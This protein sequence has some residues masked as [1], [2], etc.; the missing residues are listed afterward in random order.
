[1]WTRSAIEDITGTSS[2]SMLMPPT[3][4][5]RARDESAMAASQEPPPPTRP[6][7]TRKCED[8]RTKAGSFGVPDEQIRRW[9]GDCAR[10]HP[11]SLS[12]KRS[13]KALARVDCPSKEARRPAAGG[14]HRPAARGDSTRWDH[15]SLIRGRRAP[16]AANICQ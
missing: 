15:L 9:C 6:G 12:S 5:P 3:A 13:P 11:G 8:Y 4:T 10:S 14:A 7:G 2:A 16:Q 1:M